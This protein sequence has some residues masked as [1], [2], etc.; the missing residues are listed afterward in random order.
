MRKIAVSIII[1]VVNEAD[2]IADLL[3]FLRTDVNLKFVEIIISDGGSSDTTLQIVSNFK[4]VRLVHST[5]GRAV[6]MNTGAE[7]A[8]GE[9]LYFLHADTIPPKGFIEALLSSGEEAA[10]FR[11]KFNNSTSILLRGASFFT[12][13]Q[14]RLFRGGDQS[15]FL[16]RT[17]FNE[18]K[19]FNENY[20][21]YEDVEFIGRLRKIAKF[22][23]LKEYVVTSA[24]RFNK[25]GTV[26]LFLHFG[27]IHLKFWN[28]HSPHSI[29]AY[30][31]KWIK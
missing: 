30:Y 16:K 4:E 29:E 7:V 9:Y 18:L 26:R 10:C 8:C 24:R 21:V 17:L 14:G 3:N 19:G 20:K 6:Q 31:Q 1:P 27:V 28:G 2:S 25:N 15:L 12:Q 11:L 13:F 22:A 5:T 23:I